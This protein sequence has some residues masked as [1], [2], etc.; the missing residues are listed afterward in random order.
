MASH[1]AL[2]VG[3]ALVGTG[4]NHQA[5]NANDGG[6]SDVAAIDGGDAAVGSKTPAEGMYGAYYLFPRDT[7][8][9]TTANIDGARSNNKSASRIRSSRSRG[10]PDTSTRSP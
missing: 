5:E 8:A 1:V 4:C 9:L 7:S 10:R 2:V 3:L 6:G